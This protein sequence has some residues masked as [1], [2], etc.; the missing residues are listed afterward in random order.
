ME[1]EKKERCEEREVDREMERKKQR[2]EKKL[3]VNV[4]ECHSA[5]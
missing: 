4:S 1:R 2:E 3:T 5:Y